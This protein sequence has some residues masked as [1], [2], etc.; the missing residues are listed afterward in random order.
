[1]KKEWL[2]TY[3]DTSSAAKKAAEIAKMKKQQLNHGEFYPQWKWDNN[4]DGV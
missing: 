3:W 2:L 4:L 1:M